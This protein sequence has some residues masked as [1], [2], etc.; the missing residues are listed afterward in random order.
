MKKFLLL[1]LVFVVPFFT[2]AQEFKKFPPVVCPA[3][4]NT[5][6]TH[7]PMS[8]KV[9]RLL[10]KANQRNNNEQTGSTFVVD[11]QGFTPEAQAA[12]Q[13]AVDIWAVLLNS[14]VPIKINAQFTDLGAGVLGSAG[15]D[16]YVRD[17]RNAPTDTTFYAIALAEKI[18]GREL[19]DPDQPEINT[20]FSSTQDWYYG[21]D[22][23]AGD[24]FDFVT[25]VLHELAHGLGFTT[26]RGFDA[27]TGV[28]SWDLVAN[29]IHVYSEAIEIEDG[30]RLVDLPNDTEA[31]GDAFTGGA[32][33]YNGPLSVETLG[34][35]RVRL[36]APEEFAGGSSIAHV[37]EDAY[38]AGDPN[39]LMSP[40]VGRGESNFDPGVALDMFADMGW[41]ITVLDHT[42]FNSAITNLSDPIAVDVTI[43][44]DTTIV[45]NNLSVTY[46]LDDFATEETITMTQVEGNTYRAEIPNPGAG[47]AVKY[48]FSGI[49]DGLGRSVTSPGTVP[50]NFYSLVVEESVTIAPPYLLA[51]GGDFE[52]GPGGFYSYPLEGGINIWELGSPGNTLTN[53]S[54]PGNVWKSDL[55][56]NIP[57]P[58]RFYRSAL[59]TPFFDMSDESSNYVL[60]F[61]L[62]MELGELEDGSLF[63]TGPLGLNVEYSLDEGAT[64]LQLGDF[65]D[66]AGDN[67]YNFNGVES[68]VIISN[69]FPNGAGWVVDSLEAFTAAYNISRFA[70]NEKV[71]FRFM[72]TVTT[73]FL[74]GGYDVDGALID[75]FQIQTGDPTA[76][77]SISNTGI[78]FPGDSVQFEY[79]SSGATSFAW[80]FGDGGTSTE[81]NPVY[82]YETGGIYDVSLTVNYN[83][84]SAE[85]V[86]ENL[87]IVVGSAGSSYTLADGG[88]FEVNNGDFIAENITGTGWERGQSSVE[89]KAGTSSGDFAWVTGINADNYVDNSEARLYTPQFDFSAFGNYSIEF[90][91]NWTF[92]DTWDGFIVE[93]TPD[94]GATW[95]KLNDNLVEGWYQTVSNPQSVFGSEVPI[96]S[97]TTNNEFQT[98][99]TD[100]SFLSGIPEVGFRFLFLTDVAVTDI[101]AAIDDFIL[102]GPT[103]GPAEIDFSVST[104][105]ACTGDELTYSATISGTITALD[106][107]FGEGAVPATASGT[108]PH[109]IAYATGG[110]KTVTLT[111]QSPVNGLQTET[112]VDIVTVGIKP[113]NNGIEIV[114]K[115][116]CDGEEAVVTVLA[117]APDVTYQ[118]VNSLNDSPLGDGVVGNGGDIVLSS[119]PLTDNVNIVVSSS[120]SVCN[121]VFDSLFVVTTRSLPTVTFNGEFLFTEGG[122]D[123]YQWFLNGEP[124]EGANDRTYIPTGTGTYFV[125]ADADGC[126]GR[127]EEITLELLAN[128]SILDPTIKVYP[129]PA[130][131]TLQLEFT[132]LGTHEV[133]IKDYLGQTILTQELEAGK[134]QL[135]IEAIANGLYILEITNPNGTSRQRLIKEN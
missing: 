49:E 106:W 127:S 113:E 69:L 97:G 126:L 66:V 37:D 22:G 8:G 123:S 33:F 31:V 29:K 99:G 76:E 121:F 90:K 128:E 108:G 83:G 4:H 57:N 53:S 91:G 100:V 19:N 82:V 81:E 59:V 72:L 16:S 120:N 67:W 74:E 15:P 105:E 54:S 28:G 134:H 86:K 58:D 117:S 21:T 101:G 24:Q 79:L 17:F 60:S 102:T 52:S 6:H 78:T 84:G 38:P 27:E 111:A 62:A 93:Y 61:E 85:V 65:G 18:A 32:L 13:F 98:F 48:Y 87:I 70:G 36:Y 96:F 94:R 114:D 95:I 71:A 124:I 39:S 47:A 131:N 75:N 104:S 42:P 109:T 80:D 112:K 56:N 2:H 51:D 1:L 50:D 73:E 129:N 130:Q 44:T 26:G 25:V 34:G 5:Y 68:N 9:E 10:A 3:D 118:L 11:Y 119:G 14:P 135:N 20:N 133:V 55:D 77:F 41:F 122:A 40:S 45:S 7:V 43:R 107:D 103:E 64:W 63:S 46:S 110:T 35:E 115:Q 12:F 92:E 132:E 116:L 125:E 88:D 30:T 23:Q 89:G